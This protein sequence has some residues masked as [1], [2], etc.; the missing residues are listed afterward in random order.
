MNY[1]FAVLVHALFVVL[2][3]LQEREGVDLLSMAAHVFVRLART[4]FSALWLKSAGTVGMRRKIQPVLAAVVALTPV[5]C[6]VLGVDPDRAELV[7]C[8]VACVELL[9]ER[10]RAALPARKGVKRAKP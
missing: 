8:A 7:Q 9:V 5:A 6:R 2:S 4:A 3:S 1:T 10:P